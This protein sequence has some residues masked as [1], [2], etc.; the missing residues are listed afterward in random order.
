MPPPNNVRQV[1]S[2]KYGLKPS[3]RPGKLLASREG[4]RCALVWRLW[5]DSRGRRAVDYLPAI[6]HRAQFVA[7]RRIVNGT[8]KPDLIAGYAETFQAG[9][10]AGGWR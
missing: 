10:Q 3:I 8:D 6:A 5:S 2:M 7:A 4:A 9:L 1:R